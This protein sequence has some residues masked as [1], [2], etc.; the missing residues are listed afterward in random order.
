MYHGVPNTDIEKIK[1]ALWN[2]VTDANVSDNV[3]TSN[4]KSKSDLSD[5]VV[6]GIN[7]SVNPYDGGARCICFVSL[8]AKDIDNIGTEDMGRL[9]EMYDA[10]ILALPYNV[11]PYTFSYERQIGR[12]DSHG[13][14]ANIFNL[15]C[16]I[17]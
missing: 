10:L 14:H 7:G 5:F 12:R 8:F 2:I 11:K 15:E 3:F 4:R 17:Y 1:T 9:T 16:K 13:F 6:V